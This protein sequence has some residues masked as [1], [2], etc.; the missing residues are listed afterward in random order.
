MPL[1]FLL[2][3]DHDVMR[4]GLHSLLASKDDWEICGE[5]KDASSTIAKVLELAPDIVILD[6]MMPGMIGMTPGMTGFE[7]AAKIRKIA[8]ST[9]IILFSLHEVPVGVEE[10]GAAAF[11]SKASGGREL[12]D[13][14][15]RVTR[16]G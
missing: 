11:V 4:A 12:L 15:D 14:I 8:P 7:I 3:D 2:A 13:T 6:L 1:R 9:K 5:S 10:S 16:N